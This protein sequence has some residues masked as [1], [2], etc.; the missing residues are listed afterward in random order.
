MS[1]DKLIM[2][3][4]KRDGVQRVWGSGEGVTSRWVLSCWYVM[5]GRVQ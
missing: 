2:P 4:V 5:V 1:S 3:N